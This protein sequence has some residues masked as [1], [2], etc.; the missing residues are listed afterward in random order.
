MS[1]TTITSIERAVHVTNIWL[2]ELMEELNWDD[3]QR[4]Y[5]AFGSVLH[6]LRDRPTVVEAADLGA[7]LPLLIRGLFYEGWHP[8]GK[9]VKE[10]KKEDFLAH[11]AAAFRGHAEVFPE[12][13]AWAAFKVL[14]RHVS[15]GEIRDIQHVLPTEIRSLWPG[16]VGIGR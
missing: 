1:L 10:R 2:K 5:H 6:A 15:A 9:P 7:Q 13:V 8:S 3:R 4:A 16:V 14:E 12:E 11:I